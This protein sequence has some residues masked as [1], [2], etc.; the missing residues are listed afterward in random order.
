MIND[1]TRTKTKS[2]DKKTMKRRK[3]H[4]FVDLIDFYSNEFGCNLDVLEMRICL[5]HKSNQTKQNIFAK[6]F[7]TIQQQENNFIILFI[8]CLGAKMCICMF[9]YVCVSP[10]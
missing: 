3:K 8:F 6:V 9:V 7:V 4:V 2:C 1:G 10:D 5:T